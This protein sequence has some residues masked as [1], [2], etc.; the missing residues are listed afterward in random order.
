MLTIDECIK[1]LPEHIVIEKCLW[2]GSMNVDIDHIDNDLNKPLNY[3]KAFNQ[4]VKKINPHNKTLNLTG[5][6]ASPA[7]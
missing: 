4:M 2:V 5:G 6:K 7:G 1:L 3:E